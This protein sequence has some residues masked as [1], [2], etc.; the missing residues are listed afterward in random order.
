MRFLHADMA[1]WIL[2]LPLVI[3]FW[4]LIVFEKRRFRRRASIG[5]RVAAL[6]RLTTWR[7]DVMVLVAAGAAIAA[8]VFAMMQPQLYLARRVAEF[9]GQDLVLLLDSSASMRAEDVAPSRLGRAV[10]EIKAFLAHKPEQLE[11]VALVGFSG[12]PLVLSQLTRD[13]DSLSFYLDWVGDGLEPQ[14][15]T[16]IA[17][18]LAS[19][20]EIVRKDRRPTKKV[21]LVVSD[22]DDSGPQLPRVLASLRAEGTRVYTIGIGTDADTPIPLSREDGVLTFVRDERGRVLTTRFNEMMLRGIAAETGGRYV[23]SLTGTELVVAMRDLFQVE[24]RQVGWTQAVEYRDVYRVALAVGG[25]FA[26]TLLLM[27]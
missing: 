7:H 2:A 5:A 22:G 1:G 26:F 16:D 8:L 11:R 18:A 3:V 12:T 19:A 9:E 24:R 20:Q 27:L 23:R 17:A 6:S 10:G 15:G 21:L 14:F 25:M 13:V 4:A